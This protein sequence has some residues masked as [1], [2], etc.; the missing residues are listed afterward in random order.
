MQIRKIGNGLLIDYKG[1]RYAID[2]VASG[3]V[4]DY[5]LVSHAHVDHLP[6]MTNIKVVAS[7]ETISLASERGYKYIR[8]KDEKIKDIECIDSGHILGSK[9]FLIDGKI[10]Y[11]GDVNIQK[12]LF[13]NGFD[14]PQADI[15][16]IEATYG[17]KR[18]VFGDFHSLIDKLFNRISKLLLRG[19]NIVLQAH[20]LG[21]TQLLT[22]ILDWYP[23]TYVS[24]YIYRFNEVYYE[25]K[26]LRRTGNILDDEADEPFILIDSIR[27]N[28]FVNRYRARN[29]KL[30]GW[31][32][33]DLVNGLPIS[34]HADFY[35]LLRVVDKVSP[36]KIYTV[37]GFTR[38][39][40]EYLKEYGYDAE[41]FK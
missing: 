36:K 8:E 16:I 38:R 20:P 10:L 34:D 2:K 23:Y 9:A 4:A 18:Y 11:T 40:A 1:K 35:D 25:F 33:T 19:E 31:M 6:N 7:D 22:D 17:D 24:P 5:Y 39:F 21:K 13:L 37:H 14:P 30:S 32:V 3:T 15:L 12:R 26:K 28:Y 27:N 29:I 41:P